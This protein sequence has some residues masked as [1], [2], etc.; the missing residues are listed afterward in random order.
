MQK[1]WEASSSKA[2]QITPVRASWEPAARGKQGSQQWHVR[3]QLEQPHPTMQQATATQSTHI[4]LGVSHGL[5]HRRQ[6]AV[7]RHTVHQPAADVGIH[8]VAALRNL[9]NGVPAAGSKMGTIR[10]AP[11]QLHNYAVHH[12]MLL[13]VL[14]CTWLP[15]ALTRS[16]DRGRLPA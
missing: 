8:R 9:R 16:S 6:P 5:L 3:E 12:S 2:G 14:W 10:Q 4:G 7:C 15:C 11:G 13:Q 1:G